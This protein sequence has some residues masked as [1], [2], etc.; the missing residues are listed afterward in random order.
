MRSYPRNSP[1]AATRIVALVVLSDGHVSNSELEALKKLDVA[2]DLGIEPQDVS[3][4]L[5][6]LCEDLLMAGFDGRSIL[7]HAGDGLIAPLMAEVDDPRLQG[8]I[9]RA[10]ASVV[11]V[12]K[13][14][15]DGETAMLDAIHRHWQTRSV[16][17]VRMTEAA[18]QPRVD[19]RALTV[20][21]LLLSRTGP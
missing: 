12:D 3:G 20:R 2:R 4:I 17:M 15:S 13:H 9:L 14:L 18:R 11:N 8:V 10:A 21:A 16:T 6:T 7:S 1:E 19:A 5:Q